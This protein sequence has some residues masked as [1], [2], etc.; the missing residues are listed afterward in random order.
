MVSVR[1]PTAA[2]PQVTVVVTLTER[3]E[4]AVK[5]EDPVPVRAGVSLKY[6]NVNLYRY[7]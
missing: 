2:C 3:K 1:C 7:L 4:S 6:A 5:A